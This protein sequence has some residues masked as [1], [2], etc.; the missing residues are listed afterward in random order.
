MGGGQLV[1]P[2]GLNTY[3]T[4][5]VTYSGLTVGAVYTIDSMLVATVHVGG[6]TS[7]TPYG[8][9]NID[10]AGNPSGLYC[11]VVA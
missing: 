8:E 6:G 10:I 11:E 4:L 7:W 1:H 3:Y 9:M 2:T 5:N